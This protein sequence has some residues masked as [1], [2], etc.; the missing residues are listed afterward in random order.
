MDWY[1]LIA[2]LLNGLQLGLLLFLLASGLSLIFGDHGLHQPLPRLVLHDRRVRLRQ[3][4]GADRLFHYRRGGGGHR[5][6][7]PRCAGGMAN[8][9]QTI[10]AEITSTTCWSPTA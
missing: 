2:Q 9:A 1:L 3:R 4:D 5:G 8:R 7:Y 6:F 10:L